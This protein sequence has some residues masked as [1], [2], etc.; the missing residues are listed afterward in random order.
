MFHRQIESIATLKTALNKQLAADKIFWL[1]MALQNITEDNSQDS[2]QYYN[3]MAKRKL[4]SIILPFLSGRTQWRTDEAGR[5][6]LLTQWLKNCTPLE[7]ENRVWSAYRLGDEFEKIAIVKSLAIIDIKGELKKLSIHAGRTNNTDLFAAIALEN[8]YPA[9]FY[10]DNAFNHLA[11]KS[12][13]LDFDPVQIF[14][15]S[16][17]LNFQLSSLCIDL[18]KERF[19]AGRP[20]PLAIALAINCSHL[21]KEEHLIYQQLTTI[22][23]KKNAVF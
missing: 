9:S 7:K 3:A 17:R 14:G 15:L 2:Y 4:D 16:E 13:F 18:I 19:A 22:T 11:I 21:N 20:A 10:D 8:A 12:L 6:L 23:G 1:E 5:L